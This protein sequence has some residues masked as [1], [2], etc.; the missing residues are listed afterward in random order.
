MS[1]FILAS[2]ALAADLPQE[3]VRH[4]EGSAG[5]IVAA[6]QYILSGTLGEPVVSAFVIAG[7]HKTASGYWRG[8]SPNA[9]VFLPVVIK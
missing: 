5:Q 1:V 4:V 6:G 8:I 2:T 3:I 7:D 9:K